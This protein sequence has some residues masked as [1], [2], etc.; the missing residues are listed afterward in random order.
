M[1]DQVDGRL[2]DWVKSVLKD[3]TVSLAAPDSTRKSKSIGVYLLEFIQPPAPR[4]TKRPPLQFSLRYLITASDQED[5]SAHHLLSELLLAAMDSNDFEVESEPV[6]IALWSAFGIAPRPSFVLRVPVRIERP[7]PVAKR[8]R[9][10]IVLN[11]TSMMPLD[12]V[13]L[14]PNDIPLAEAEVELPALQLFTHTD[15]KGRFRFSA[16]PAPPPEMLVRVAA[17]GRE[18]TVSTGESE[19]RAGESLVVRIDRM[20][21]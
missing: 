1:I 14:G 15:F 17:K 6:P 5:E 21:D 11:K 8:V 10:P 20:E 4:T 18:V 16:V 2:R 7:Q 9:M 3:V 19:R 13:V 12:G